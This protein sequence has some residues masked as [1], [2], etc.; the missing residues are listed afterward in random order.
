MR[1]ACTQALVPRQSELYYLALID[2]C[3]CATP[4]SWY[5]I[6]VARCHRESYKKNKGSARSKLKRRNGH[7][8]GFQKYTVRRVTEDYS[9]VGQ[10]ALSPSFFN[11]PSRL[12]SSA[13]LYPQYTSHLRM[14]CL[15]KTSE[16][17]VGAK[18][19]I[20][21]CECII[22]HRVVTSHNV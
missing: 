4:D 1:T 19:S 18:R 17:S 20:R 2:N 15:H 11:R 8:Q 16:A 7:K 13:V 10:I 5:I 6:L 14:A 9:A 21:A 3:T 12:A 22:Q